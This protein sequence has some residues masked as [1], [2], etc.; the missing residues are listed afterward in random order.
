MKTGNQEQ[1]GVSDLLFS[2]IPHC[3]CKEFAMTWIRPIPPAEAGDKLKR[4]LQEQRLAKAVRA[5][6]GGMS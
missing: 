4:L 5:I 1:T 3:L 2:C 6:T